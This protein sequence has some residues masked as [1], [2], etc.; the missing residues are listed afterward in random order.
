[1]MVRTLKQY[2]FIYDVLFEAL[3]TTYNVVGADLKVNYRELSR[4][5][6]ASNKSCFREQF[7]V[8]E[9][10]VPAVDPTQTVSALTGVNRKK[11]RFGTIVASDRHRPIL[12]TPC[13]P[14]GT[15]YINALYVDTYSRR[16]GFVV[17][18]TPLASTVTDFW[19]L[20]YD[21]EITTIV[22]MNGSDFKEDSCAEY[23]PSG[24]AMRNCEPFLIKLIDSVEA[25]HV[26]VRTAELTCTL[27][28][29]ARARHVRQFRFESWKMYDKVPWSREG[30]LLLLDAVSDWQRQSAFPEAPVLVH[31][32]DGASQSGLYC[33]SVVLCEKMRAN[34]QVD[35]FHT[36]KR[37]K[38]RRP[39]FVNSLVGGVS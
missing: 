23:W 35:V 38:K 17:T 19:K 5:N 27:N 37:M 22:L 3:I 18:Q 13:S 9:E 15:D 7:E 2:L 6:P 28:P 32:M 34:G 36:V 14:G 8:L 30:F 11:N 25:D 10:F 39:H 21:Y 12:K 20:V 24:A 1:M 33:A 29:T 31:C 26:T 16:N 4:T